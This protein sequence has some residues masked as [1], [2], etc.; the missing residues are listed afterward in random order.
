HPRALLSVQR[1]R[2]LTAAQR[3]LRHQP[4]RSG[5]PGVLPVQGAGGAPADFFDPDPQ[6]SVRQPG[7]ID[8]EA[9]R[10]EFTGPTPVLR[11]FLNTLATYRLPLIVSSVEVEPAAADEP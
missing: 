2:P 4:S 11:D 3:A 10:L 9:F 1:E 5:A 8:S 6:L 7:W